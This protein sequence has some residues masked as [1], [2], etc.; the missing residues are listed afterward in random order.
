VYPRGN[1]LYRVKLDGTESKKI[2]S[3][4]QDETPSWPRWSPDGSRL[5]FSV[6]GQSRGTS[7]WEVSGDRK[8][9][10]RL[11]S[12][13]NNPPS[14]C[15][16]GWTPDGKYFLFQSGRGG[17]TNIWAIR[18]KGSFFR[19]TSDE[20]MQLTT[21][22]TPTYNPALSTDGKKVFV[23]AAQDRGELVRYDSASHQFVPYLSGIS[24]M[25]VN[26]SR[27]GKWVT[28][29]AYP[30]GTLW[31]SKVDGSERLQLTFP[32]LY[33]IQ[34]RWSPDG[35]R[36]AFQAAQPGTPVSVY[37]IPAQ[38]GSPERPLPGD[39]DTADPNWSPDGQ[40][41]LFGRYPPDEPPQVGSIDIEI[42]ELRSHHTSKVPGS[43]GLWSPRW[44]GDGRHILALTRAQDRVMLFD[45][46]IQK[47]TESTSV[48]VNSVNWPEWSRQGDHIYFS[49]GPTAGQ[50]GGVF[51]IRISDR[52]LE[53][54]VSLKDFRQTAA[55]WGTW[56]APAPDG[57]PL[58]VRD[59]GTHDIYA[60]DVDFP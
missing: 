10:H 20:P 30:E 1:S 3:V 17:T 35:T 38:G 24:A 19:K 51:R 34:P 49:A 54:V 8:I 47:W 48:G 46:K 27:D 41:L 60:L 26:V 4:A 18:E 42:V 56:T 39:R 23:V 9:L 37:V 45:V 32:P 53:Q 52:K 5:R 13:W 43:E 2:V 55:G 40:A 44:S 50:P 15:C 33:A 31:R 28:Y 16:G 12:G 57:S 7:L 29:V 36:I 22:P 59:A 25:G 14:E 6:Q 21:G 11:L 58:L